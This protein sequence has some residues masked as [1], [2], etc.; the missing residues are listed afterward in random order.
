MNSN[1]TECTYLVRERIIY[2][3]KKVSSLLYLD[4]YRKSYKKVRI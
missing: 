1:R 2:L 3:T 4:E